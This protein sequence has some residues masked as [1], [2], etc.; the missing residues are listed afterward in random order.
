VQHAARVWNKEVGVRWSDAR[1]NASLMGVDR[2]DFASVAFYRPD[3]AP[4]CLGALMN[5]LAVR[6]DAVLVSREFMDQGIEV[7]DRIEIHIPIGSAPKVDFTVG[8]VVD[9]FPRMYPEDGAFMIANLAF[10]FDNAGGIYP[11]DVWLKTAPSLQLEA[12]AEGAKELGINV[13][14]AY[15]ARRQIDNEQLR[16]ERQ[17][18]LGLLSVGFIAAAFLT[19][20][21]FLIYSYI[22]FVQ[23]YIEL[24]VLRAI[25]LSI[26]QMATFLVAEQLTL[27]ATGAAAGTGLGVLASRLFIP[28]FQVQGGEHPFTPPFVVQ[29]AWTE[30]QYIYAIF[31]V[32]FVAAVI[33]LL[34]SLRRMRVFEAVK[35]GETT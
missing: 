6:D 22:S 34:V 31:G 26:G 15:S 19:V 13:M 2:V 1:L 4:A 23:R 14:R 10:I 27:I 3:F 7:G 21:G 30:I 12:L 9:L 5:A 16:P 18:V 33:V 25:G 28:F 29:I 24:G 35:L 32:M 8:G 20:L 11:Y 17:G